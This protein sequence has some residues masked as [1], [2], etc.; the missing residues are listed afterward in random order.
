[1]SSE[2]ASEVSI[3]PVL[4]TLELVAGVFP[5]PV[6]DTLELVVRVSGFLWETW[7]DSLGVVCGHLGSSTPAR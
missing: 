7:W 3:A 6:L 2:W 4:G 5:A 1:M